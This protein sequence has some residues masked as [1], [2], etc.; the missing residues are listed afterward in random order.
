MKTMITSIP[1]KC[2]KRKVD[3]VDI[4]DKYRRVCINSWKDISDN[5]ISVNN[6]IESNFVKEIDCQI[7]VHEVPS[8]KFA[9]TNKLLVLLDDMLKAAIFSNAEIVI[10]TNSDIFLSKKN[11][12]EE[13]INKV[14]PGCAIV[15]KRTNIDSV[16]QGIGC[17]YRLGYDLFIMHKNDLQKNFSEIPLFFGEPWWDYFLL[18][19]M[20]LNNINI[21]SIDSSNVLHVSHKPTFSKENWI[22]IGIASITE[23][24]KYEKKNRYT[25]RGCNNFY[26]SKLIKKTSKR[27]FKKSF[28]Q[29]IFKKEYSIEDVLISFS[30]DLLFFSEKKLEYTDS[31]QSGIQKS[32]DELKKS[33]ENITI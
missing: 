18:C 15:S 33:L 4:G 22:K 28:F 21:M 13:K 1:G 10:I 27:I 23:L 9:N 14:Q 3:H 24:I 19:K 29:R 25:D 31:T 12:L 26:M 8:A 7:E 5:I 32:C 16:L 20:I 2:P 17:T 30:E 6:I 11:E